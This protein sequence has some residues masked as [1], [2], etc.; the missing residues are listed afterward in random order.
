VV[1]SAPE[2]VVASADTDDPEDESDPAARQTEE[3]A[4]AV[5]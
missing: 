5:G 3:S 4:V 1:V 2:E